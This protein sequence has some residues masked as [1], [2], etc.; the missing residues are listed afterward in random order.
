MMFSAYGL[1][2]KRCET[3]QSNLNLDEDVLEKELREIENYNQ[4]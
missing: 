3:N 2:N 1:T 4:E